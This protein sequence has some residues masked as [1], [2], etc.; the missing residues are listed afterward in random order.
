MGHTSNIQ[1]NQKT[2]FV[3]KITVQKLITLLSVCVCVCVYEKKYF[4]NVSSPFAFTTLTNIEMFSSNEVG[5]EIK[6]YWVIYLSLVFFFFSF[7][8][9]FPLY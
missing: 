8:L 6:V 5:Y 2:L 7:F 1:K 3:K 9:F 4:K